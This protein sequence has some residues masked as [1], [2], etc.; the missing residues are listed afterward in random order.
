MCSTSSACP[1]ALR[2][3][4]ER[5][6]SYD[7]VSAF[8][9]LPCAYSRLGSLKSKREHQETPPPPGPS[10]TAPWPTHDSPPAELSFNANVQPS[11]FD[12]WLHPIT[13]SVVKPHLGSW[14]MSWFITFGITSFPRATGITVPLGLCA[15][16]PFSVLIREMTYSTFLFL[17]VFFGHAMDCHWPSV[18]TLI[19][20]SAAMSLA[21]TAGRG[22]RF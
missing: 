11:H 5:S 13:D 3:N 17:C 4:Q 18:L 15:H 1:S 16:Q 2:T 19:R 20:H 7:E 12:E 6:S 8:P 14:R 21:L 10:E 22:K 9:P